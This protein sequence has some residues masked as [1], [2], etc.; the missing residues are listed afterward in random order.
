MVKGKKLIDAWVNVSNNLEILTRWSLTYHVRLAAGKEGGEWQAAIRG[1]PCS[2]PARSTVTTGTPSGT[3]ATRQEHDYKLHFAIS[4]TSYHILQYN[5]L[6]NKLTI[7]FSGNPKCRSFNSHSTNFDPRADEA[8]LDI[9][10]SE[11]PDKNIDIWY[12]G[13]RFIMYGSSS[14]KGMK[15]SL[16]R[17]RKR[18]VSVEGWVVEVQ[19]GWNGIP[20]TAEVFTR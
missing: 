1:P 2:N 6:W 4:F 5:E 10:Q 11:N 15:N 9:K 14:L 16:L 7:P 17:V 20:N 8:R 12:R 13:A 3:T 18:G 19:I